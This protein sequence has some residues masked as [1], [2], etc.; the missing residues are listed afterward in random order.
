MGDASMDRDE[1]VA[2]VRRLE[3]ASLSLNDAARIAIEHTQEL[4][5]RHRIAE[6]IV[7]LNFDILPQIYDKHPDLRPPPE[8]PRISSRL[9][10]NKVKLPSSVSEKDIDDILFPLLKRR[11][12]KVALVLSRAGDH[13]EPLGLSLD[14]IA[15]RLRELAD[16]DRIEGAGD[17]RMW[18]FS[19]V[20]LKD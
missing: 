9:R 17:L 3:E 1:A 8:K 11:W 6:L 12:Q 10:W 15:A 2:I 7:A 18:R 20:R 5:L 16:T 19:E 14:I 13:F 4:Q